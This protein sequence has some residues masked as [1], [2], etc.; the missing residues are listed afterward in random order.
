MDLDHVAIA[1]RDVLP[2]MDHL[3]GVLGGTLLHGGEAVGFRPLQIRVGDARSGMTVELLEPWRVGE[4]D[5]LERFVARRGPGPHHLTFKVADIERTLRDV[6]AAGFPPTVVNI[7]SELWREAFLDPRRTHGTVIQ[8]AEDHVNHPD[9]GV[10]LEAARSGRSSSTWTPRWWRDPPARAAEAATLRAVV[11]G[12]PSLPD[13]QGFFGGLLGGRVD[14][15]GDGWVELRWPKA[16]GLR[17]VERPGPARIEWL[18]VRADDVA[19]HGEVVL[20]GTRIVVRAVD[21]PA[22]A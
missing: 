8:F 17:L 19:V 2:L 5:F 21:D 7:D 18:D 16:A 9:V 12:T 3:V 1:D 14:A 11:L 10:A 22:V 20:S 6:T 15:D 4:N 13:A